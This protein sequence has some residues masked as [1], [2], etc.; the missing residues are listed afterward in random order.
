VRRLTRRLVPVLAPALMVVALG[1]RED[2]ESPTAPAPEPA[3]DI[4]PAHALSFRQISGGGS[5]TCGVTTDNRAYCWGFNRDGQLGIGTNT[6]PETGPYGSYSATPVAVVGTLSFRQVSAGYYHTCGVTT[7]YRAYCWGWNVEGRLGDGSTTN[8]LRPTPVAGGRQFRLVDA[9]AFGTC[10]VTTDNQA[11]CWGWNREGQLGVGTNTG[12]ET[13]TIPVSGGTITTPCSTRPV[14]VRGG[15]QFRQVAAAAGTHTCGVTTDNRAYCWGANYAGQLGDSTE[16]VRR[17][18]PSRVAGARQFRQVDVGGG[19]TCGVTT[20]DRAFCWGGGRTGQLGNGKTYKSF[21]PRRVA[22]GLYFDRISAGQVHNCGE[23]TDN[24]AYCWG[25]NEL[26]GLGD[27]TTT[28]RLTPVPVAGGLTFSQVSVGAFY[29]CGKT[30]A[31]VAYCWG[32][33]NTGQLGDGTT[34]DRLTPV[35]VAGGT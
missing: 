21:W 3:L 6:G 26:G 33:N 19:H 17:L 5:H 23:T 13:C 16:V 12:P 9:G 28:T 1:C 20:G 35:A 25:N 22:G 7:D 24:R 10:G 30:P 34:T 31:S 4:T 18:E 15:L 32:H 11:Y 8:R 27:G 2:A 14:A 29:T